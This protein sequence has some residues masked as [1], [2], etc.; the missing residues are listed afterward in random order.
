MHHTWRYIMELEN[1][2]PTDKKCLNILILKILR[3]YTDE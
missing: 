2:I 1:I 3:E